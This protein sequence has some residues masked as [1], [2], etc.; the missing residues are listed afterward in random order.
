PRAPDFIRLARMDKPIG[1]YLLLWPTLTALWIAA[2][3]FPGLHLLLVFALGT[4]L[5]RSAGCVLNDMADMK[6][7]GFVKRTQG[8]PLA[9]GKVS[10]FE[11]LLFAG[12]ILL[13]ALLLVLTT[14]ET[15]VLMTIPAVVI[16]AIYPLMKR[17][18]Y[19]P[20]AILGV[21]FSWGILMAFTATQDVLPAM[22]WLLL[23]ANLLWVV[24]YD[25][26]Y[27]MVDRD[28]DIRLGL[29][30]TAILFAELDRTMIGVLQVSWLGAM[31]LAGHQ[32]GLSVWY[33]AALGGAGALFVYQQYLIKDR[34]RDECF[35]A[36][37]NNH[38]VGLIVFV[39]VVVHYAL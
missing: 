33:Y 20:Q 6:F 35:E 23:T 4:W 15:T 17:Y 25:T 3:G 26:E 16:T 18:T 14:N 11:A 38:W 32:A 13:L 29:K 22:A 24:A 34:A 9:T 8:R 39:G 36:F 5:T 27:A 19:L 31:L 2:G 10:R 30:S 37:L 28:D 1:T 21:A 7:D 12:A